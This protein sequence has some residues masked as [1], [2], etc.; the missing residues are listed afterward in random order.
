MPRLGHDFPIFSP[1]V[2]EKLTID[3]TILHDSHAKSD[4]SL[5]DWQATHITYLLRRFYKLKTN[6]KS[7]AVNRAQDYDHLRARVVNC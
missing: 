3:S 6:Q 1:V 4:V 2:Q 5:T 7:N